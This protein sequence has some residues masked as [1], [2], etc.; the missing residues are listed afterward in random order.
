MANADDAASQR[1][2]RDM[3]VDSAFEASTPLSEGS[4]PGVRAFDYPAMSPEPVIALDAT[5][6]NTRRNAELAQMSAATRK[7]I[8]LVGMQ[9]VL[10]SPG[11]T[12]A[13]TH[14]W[15]GIDQSLEHRRVMPI[16]ACDTEDQRRSA[17]CPGRPR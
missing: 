7:V 4:Q 15:Q 10:P 6:G 13:A 9:L 17:G 12:A 16:G 5:P 3:K 8:A 14:R 11:P 1:K 2:P